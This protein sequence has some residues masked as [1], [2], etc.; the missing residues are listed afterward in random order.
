MKQSLVD[1]NDGIG[2]GT[3]G[4]EGTLGYVIINNE[5]QQWTSTFTT[6]MKDGRYCD[7]VQGGKNTDGTSCRGPTYVFLTLILPPSLSD[8]CLS[9]YRVTVSGGKL[10]NLTVGS[11]YAL[12][13]HNGTASRLA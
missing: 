12:A 8:T 3:S 6:G 11:Y 7:V 9:F 10:I 1:A 13:I 5:W 2:V 4:Y